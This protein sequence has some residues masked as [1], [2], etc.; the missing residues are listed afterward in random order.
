MNPAPNL[1]LVGPM[2]AG[3]TTVGR[4][5][6]ELMHL[7]FVDLDEAVEAHTGARV[8]LIF[9]IEG[10]AGFRR[11]ERSL[12]AEHAGRDGFVLATGGGVVLDGDN[13]AV[14][15]E[16][17]FVVWL[18]AG[19]DAQIAR[20]ERDRQRPLLAGSD[21]RERLLALAAHRNPL[22]REVADLRVPTEGVGNAPQ[23]ARH[24]HDLL[25]AQWRRGAVAA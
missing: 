12:L 6:A 7:P 23:L 13:R 25:A 8:P 21:R 18:D 22:Y 2:G 20:L 11:R 1:F 9:E 10:E 3:K 17:G 5:L 19:I 14:L 4:H 24:L 15:R 16:H